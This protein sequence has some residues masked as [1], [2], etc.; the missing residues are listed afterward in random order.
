MRLTVELALKQVIRAVWK[1]FDPTFKHILDR[2]GS[3]RQ[4]LEMKVKTLNSRT[5]NNH[6]SRY[7]EDM[8]VIQY[9]L[10]G[11]QK[12]CDEF[13]EAEK[14]RQEKRHDE[15]QGWI[16]S[17]DVER[18]HLDI[19]DDLQQYPGSGHWILSQDKIKDWL[20]PDNSTDSLLCVNGNPGTGK[21]QVIRNKEV[22]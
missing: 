20:C 16:A 9:H 7:T 17:P 8:R 11:Y 13:V 2:L 12:S 21:S 19:Q 15:L 22:F 4:L 5:L 1:S 3:H 18:E 10:Q 14:D 6:V